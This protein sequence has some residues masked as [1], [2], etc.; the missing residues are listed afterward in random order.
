MHDTFFTSY[1]KPQPPRETHRG[2]ERPACAAAGPAIA[3]S[4][5]GRMKSP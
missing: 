3:F 2:E 5:G 4:M 1:D